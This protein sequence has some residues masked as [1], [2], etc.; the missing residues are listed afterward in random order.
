MLDQENQINSSNSIPD[1][2]LRIF[3]AF[4]SGDTK[5]DIV[6]KSRSVD[7]EPQKLWLDRSGWGFQISAHLAQACIQGIQV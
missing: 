6:P 1:R 5:L 7:F 4:E 3:E 2:T